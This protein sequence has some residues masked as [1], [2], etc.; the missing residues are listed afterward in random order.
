MRKI[1]LKTATAF[2][3]RK[4]MK[5]DNTEVKGRYISTNGNG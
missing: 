2:L 3:S 4:A 1:T 5:M